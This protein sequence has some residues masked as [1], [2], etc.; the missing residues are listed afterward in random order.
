MHT[1]TKPINKID[2]LMT[3][4]SQYNVLHHFSQK[5]YEA[6]KRSGYDS[7]LLTRNNRLDILTKDPPELTVSFNGLPA[8]EGEAIM[9]DLLKVPHLA[10]L[11]DP[12]FWGSVYIIDSPYII[13][14]C[15][16]V[17]S[18]T[19]LEQ[20]KFSRTLFIPHAVEPELAPDPLLEKIYDV[21]LLATFIDYKAERASWKIQ[22]PLQIVRIMEEAAEESF[23]EPNVSFFQAYVSNFYAL[24]RKYSLGELSSSVFFD[25]L[26]SLE[27]YVKGKD[28]AQLIK[29]LEGYP[30]HIFGNTL[31]KMNWKSY[32]GDRY[33]HIQVHES[34]NFAQAIDIMKRSKIL[35]NPSLK[36]QYGTH[37]RFFAGT[38]CGALVV[39]SESHFLK[40][41]FKENE[42]VILYQHSHLDTL[43]LIIKDLLQNE[44]K[45]TAIAEKARAKVML[46]HT[47]DARIQKFMPIV[48][49]F[50]NQIKAST[51]GQG[52]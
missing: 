29:A 49:E 26:Q 51:K 25:S 31:H 42:E 37:E 35:L 32:L 44:A 30:V 10:I 8:M 27:K 33:P 41:N 9:C 43:N 39:S 22:F 46:H 50:I 5:L 36:N 6:L 19:F 12:P 21:T 15:D 52:T 40:S 13:L 23:A 7:R 17:Y 38:A 28:R 47:W 48:Q 18:C 34:V 4:T 1:N 20:L 24:A 45:R 11:V 16:D 14:G 2:V 3:D